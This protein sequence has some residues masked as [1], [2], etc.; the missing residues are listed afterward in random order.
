MVHCSR[1]V[2]SPVPVV[3]SPL[4]PP[5]EEQGVVARPGYAQTV[6]IGLG[7]LVVILIIVA[8]IYFLRRA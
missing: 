8:I 5:Q 7:T 6:Y 3:H 4:S 2:H 1:T